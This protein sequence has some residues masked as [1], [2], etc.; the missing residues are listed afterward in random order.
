MHAESRFI[1][2]GDPEEQAERIGAYVDMGFRH[3]IFH[4]PAPDQERFLKLFGSEVLPLLRAALRVNNGAR[5]RYARGGAEHALRGDV[6]LD[7]ALAGFQVAERRALVL[8]GELVGVDAVIVVLTPLG[9]ASDL[10]VVL[11]VLV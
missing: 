8:E 5:H 6:P 3:L 4:S 10:D 1:V 2:S 7:A 11:V 9:P